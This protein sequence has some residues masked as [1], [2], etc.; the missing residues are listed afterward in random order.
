M[1]RVTTTSAQYAS[2]DWRA[3]V[4]PSGVVVVDSAATPDLV[5]RLWAALDAGQGLHGML[6]AL[7]AG[8]AGAFSTLPP[9]AI[10]LRE[11]GATRIAVRGAVTVTVAGATLSGSGVTTW[12]E[13]LI[14][15]DDAVRISTPGAVG[16]DLDLVVRDG[17]V[18]AS[19][20]EL[21]WATDAASTGEVPAV[22]VPVVDVPV[23]EVPLSSATVVPTKDA[24][25]E[26]EPL[27]EQVVE[28]VDASAI[29][30]LATDVPEAAASAPV[31]ELPVAPDADP[32]AGWLVDSLP[33]F[34]VP[35]VAPTADA[36]LDLDASALADTRVVRPDEALTREPAEAAP[37]VDEVVVEQ[38]G[39]HDGETISLAQARALRE[40]AA[41]TGDTVPPLAPPRMP[42]PGR[43]R[44]STGAIVPLDRTVVIG[45]RPRST[46]VSGTDLPR[47]IAVDSPQ[48]DISRSHLELRVE[49]DTIVAT[50]LQTTNGTMLLRAGSS[51][52]RLHP[53]EPTVVVPGD[54]LDLGDGITVDVEELA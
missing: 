52:T 46:R 39:D 41:R 12:S 5:V 29:E 34:G 48:Q 17:I 23:V 26:P 7:T 6:D 47:L 15:G 2:G 18:R 51:P 16:D 3:A 20:I 31:V 9:F 33:S 37:A 32:L 42:A 40:A 38:R 8:H 53:G 14:S 1:T 22:A 25:P 30:A 10:V 54:L 24:E 44:L 50:D 27:P 19:V 13:Q 28:V 36:E 43:L 45:R 35:V 21:Q 4:T 11:A 49:G